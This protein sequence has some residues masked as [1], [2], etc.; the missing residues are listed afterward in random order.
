MIQQKTDIY[1][2]IRKTK[3]VMN[4]KITIEIHFEILVYSKKENILGC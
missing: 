2:V 4:D 1:D 3:E